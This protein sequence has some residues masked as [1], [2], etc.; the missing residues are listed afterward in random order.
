MFC[1]CFFSF[2]L[3]ISS[4]CSAYRQVVGDAFPLHTHTHTH[5]NTDKQQYSIQ[6]PGALL[7]ASLKKFKKHGPPKNYLYFEKRNFLALI[8]KFFSYISGN[9][10]SEKDSLQFRKWKPSK[11]FLYFGK[12]NFSIQARKKLLYFRKWKPQKISYI[13]LKESFSYISGNGNPLP[14]KKSLCFRKKVY[15]SN[16]SLYFRKRVFLIFEEMETLKSFL[17][18]RKQLFPVKK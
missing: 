18:F 12:Q 16:K 5:I 7:G 15:I 11:S 1:V 9:E 6:L 13:L 8:L 3:V 2:Q 10:D 14:P 4:L 17:Y